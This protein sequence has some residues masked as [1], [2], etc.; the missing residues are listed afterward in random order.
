MSAVVRCPKNP[1]HKKF[2]TTAHEVHDWV[3]DEN[4]EFLKDLGCSEVAAKPDTGNI[5]TCAI[6]KT[7]AEKI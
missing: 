7:E 6:C 3:V 2:I 4:G 5:W 1:N